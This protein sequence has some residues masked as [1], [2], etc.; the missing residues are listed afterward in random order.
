MFCLPLPQF[1]IFWSI[2]L[3]F[4][5]Q[6]LKSLFELK[7]KNQNTLF[8]DF[9]LSSK[10]KEQFYSKKRLESA[11]FPKFGKKCLLPYVSVSLWISIIQLRFLH[12][13][14]L[15][16]SRQCFM[17]WNAARGSLRPSLN[18]DIKRIL[19]VSLS[20]VTCTSAF[21]HVRAPWLCRYQFFVLKTSSF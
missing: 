1:T 6:Y 12:L 17:T 15:C 21:C 2:L 18:S 10:W 3:E 5:C 8:W 7:K 14:A 9:E 11:C 13:G 20:V 19:S 16:T 4:H